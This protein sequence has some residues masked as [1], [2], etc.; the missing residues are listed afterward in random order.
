MIRAIP[1]IAAGAMIVLA[2]PSLAAPD[3]LAPLETSASSSSS[4]ATSMANVRPSAFGSVALRAG[5]TIYDARFRRV[6]STDRA[7]PEVL[8]LARQL[9]G[10]SPR[11]Q[12][13]RAHQLVTSRVRF[14]TDSEALKVS[15]LWLNAGET[16]QSGRGDDEDIAI[17]SMQVLKAAGFPAENL[18]LSV[19]R[20]R[21]IGAHTILLAR[22]D[23]GFYALDHLRTSPI[24]ANVASNE[25]KPVVTIGADGSWVHGYRVARR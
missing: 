23:D 13:V 17:A 5:V 20:M 21:G 16:L 22:T 19:G 18:Y 7:A 11:A 15:D 6:S 24:A 10:L 4:A 3:P 25:F 9:Q 14:V 12:L 8:S 1:A 2:T